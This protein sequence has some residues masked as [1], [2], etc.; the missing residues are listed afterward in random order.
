M[1]L[2]RSYAS[3]QGVDIP[4]DTFCLNKSSPLTRSVHIDA[5]NGETNAMTK[6]KVR[7]VLFNN[8]LS[9]DESPIVFMKT[10]HACQK[11]LVGHLNS[12]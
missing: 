2:N 3:L 9:I 7:T 8:S 5:D 6:I 11:N 10:I 12:K 1:S 4:L